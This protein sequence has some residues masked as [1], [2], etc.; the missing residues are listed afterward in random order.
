MENW[1]KK[2]LTVT[3]EAVGQLLSMWLRATPAL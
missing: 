2:L 3:W 1:V